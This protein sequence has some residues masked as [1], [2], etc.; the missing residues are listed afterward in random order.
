MIYFSYCHIFKNANSRR[1]TKRPSIRVL[2]HDFVDSNCFMAS[3]G[4]SQ[5]VTGKGLPD[6]RV[7]IVTGDEV[8]TTW[9]LQ[10]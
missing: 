8:V 5:N 3:F 9:E 7:G 4:S 1:R 6:L 2:Q 10:A